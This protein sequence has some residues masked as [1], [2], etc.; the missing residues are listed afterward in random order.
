M[1]ISVYKDPEKD[2]RWLKAVNTVQS[3]GDLSDLTFDSITGLI[4]DSFNVPIALVTVLGH[5]KVWFKSKSGLKTSEISR[6]QSEG[7]YLV[8]RD[9][10]FEVPDLTKDPRFLQQQLELEGNLVTYYASHPIFSPG[11]FP[12]GALCI[13]DHKPKK[14]LDS[15]RKT[16]KVFAEQI[17]NQIDLCFKEIKLRSFNQK[18]GTIL[19]NIGD[20][21]FLLDEDQVF[22][23]YFTANEEHLKFPPKVF[24]N[25]KISEVGFRPDLVKLFQ[26]LFTQALQT[27]E[28]QK[29]EYNLE[30]NGKTEWF[31]VTFEKML[32]TD[33]DILCIVNNISRQKSEEIETE[34]TIKEYQDFFENTQG[35]MIKHDLD[36]GILHINNSGIR[37]LEYTKE[38]LLKINMFDLVVNKDIFSE[39]LQKIK[40]D[41]AYNGTGRLISKSG[42]TITFQ[43]NNVMFEP[44]YGAPF[45]LCNGMDTSGYLEAH[46]ELEAAAISINKE[47]TLLR[48]I[49]D[50]IPINIYTKNTNFE[51]TLINQK[52]LEYIG[53]SNE[54]EVLGKKDEELFKKE[55]AK[56]SRIEDELVIKD[57]KSII[58]KEVVLEQKNGTKR[59]CLISKLPL[60]TE[61][62]EITGMVGITN[63]IS[64]R[65][66]AEMALLEN[67]K[68]LNAI[69]TSTNTGTWEWNMSTNQI[70][71]N[72]RFWEIIGYGIDEQTILFQEDWNNLCHPEDMALKKEGLA[73]HFNK[74]TEV[75]ECEIRIKHK[76][77]HWVWV[78]EIG[79]VFSWDQEEKPL[80]MYGTFQ[81][82]SARKEFDSQL[83]AAKES[84]ENANRAKS[85]FLANMSH[86][87]RTPLNGVIGFSDLLMKTPLTETQLQYM[88]T[89]YHSAHSLLD[90]INDILDFSKI[91]AGKMELS[92]DKVDIFEL[93]TQVA[94]I[95]NYQAHSK[96]LELILNLSPHLPR[97]VYG[98]DI[99]IRQVLVNLLTNAI[100]F[101]HKGEVELKVETLENDPNNETIK[102]RFSVKDTGIGISY[103]K[104]LKI[105]D[106]FSQEDASTTRKFGGTGLGL[107]ISNKLLGLMGSKLELKSEPNQGSLF[108]F[109]LHLKSEEG[110]KEKW[111]ENH[112]L[113]KVL[114]VDDNQT[115]LYLV[116]EILEVKNIQCLEATNGLEGLQVL[117]KEWPLD[118][119]LMDLRMPFLNGIETIEKIRSLSNQNI[120]KVPVVLLS[121]SNDNELDKEKL[122]KLNVHH[123]LIK[124]IKNHQIDKVFQKLQNPSYS[125][126]SQS[127]SES[128]IDQNF[129][130][131][132]EF[133][134]LIAEDNPVNMKLSKIILSKISPTINIIEAENGLMAYEHVIKN[135][136]DLI[137]MDIQMPI[138]NGYETAKAIR[139]IDHGK[140]IPIIALTAGTV[141][142]EKERCIDSGMNDYMSKPLV[143]DKLTEKIIKLLRPINSDSLEKEELESN[144]VYKPKH[145]DKVHLLN[146]FDGDKEIGKELL[147]IAHENL[148][149]NKTYLKQALQS[150]DK[151]FLLQII[152]KIKNSAGTTG[153]FIL[154]ELTNQI[155]KAK[156]DKPLFDLGQRIIEEIDYLNE[157]YDNLEL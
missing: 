86:E 106:A 16:L 42:K 55:T 29:H 136:P 125:E 141:K 33:N 98:D 122:V 135:Q 68:R 43:I 17:E 134:I 2:S 7:F 156:E 153:F 138:M 40:S 8:T 144:T 96:G 108:Y 30:I 12:I 142:G 56:A 149:E 146:L 26:K 9:G 95:I 34:Q 27:G 97:F 32:L 41:K 109:D 103:D 72:Q 36:G 53:L 139:T 87:I 37:I 104:Q 5:D 89:V 124:P 25:K 131:N 60:K 145:F 118:L 69:I 157:T 50:N 14:L 152:K 75:Y 128:G 133:N 115:N 62:G 127:P 81:D 88:K 101:T 19:K 82:I 119:V 4:A 22:R 64:E 63:D 155:E 51:K 20:V 126:F 94:D 18:T 47:R 129:L 44:L 123:R 121:S 66:K 154:L 78:L 65:K 24:L 148:Q 143:Q 84:A 10:E 83:K 117:E 130:T 90:L 46:E 85:D 70:L 111:S 67:G 107:T 93:G 150:Q 54:K 99:R 59:F 112:G 76:D 23:E 100:K 120:A 28:K 45:V 1:S 6:K 38:E 11:G 73:K 57:G 137:L 35:L 91:E 74:E 21:V 116:K 39:Y 58:N 140:G 49:I 77:G 80:L 52:E 132:Q 114:V 31:E 13:F 113:N 71:V 110:E 3:L 92:I 79:R 151:I 102:F 48:T 147:K 15:Q 61:T 105:F